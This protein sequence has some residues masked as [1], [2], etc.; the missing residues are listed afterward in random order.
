MCSIF[1][2]F[3]HIAPSTTNPVLLSSL[4]TV[5]LTPTYNSQTWGELY[6]VPPR[7]PFK[8]ALIAPASGSAFAPAFSW[9]PLQGLLHLKRTSLPKSML[10]PSVARIQWPSSAIILRSGHL[11]PNRQL[12]RPCVLQASPWSWLHLVLHWNWFL[13]YS[14]LLPSSPSHKCLSNGHSV[15]N[16][17]H[18][19]PHRRVCFFR[20]PICDTSGPAEEGGSD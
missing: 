9:Q 15:I 14:L 13:L 17:L 3:R 20:N 1:Q 6:D 10:F 16:F 2:A 12:W 4:P 19:N 5:G 18:I 11:C 7:S 8:E